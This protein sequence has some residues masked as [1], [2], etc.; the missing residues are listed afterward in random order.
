METK[1]CVVDGCSMICTAV[2][3]TVSPVERGRS[4]M[5]EAS[6]WGGHEARARSQQQVR[7]ALLSALPVFVA[8]RIVL[9]DQRGGGPFS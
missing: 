5:Q 3:R 7:A 2:L 8:T 6:T 4:H 1:R 9:Q